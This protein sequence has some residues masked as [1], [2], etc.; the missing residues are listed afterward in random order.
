MAK[1]APT[2]QATFLCGLFLLAPWFLDLR[3][4]YVEVAI[5]VWLEAPLVEGIGPEM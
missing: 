3:E 2:F 5:V 4:R 1:G